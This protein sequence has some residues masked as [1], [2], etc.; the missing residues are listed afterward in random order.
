VSTRILES[1][2]IVLRNLR[3]GDTSR[4]ATLFTRS[5]G[6]IGGI[7]KGARDPKSPFG[8]SLELLSH[9]SFILYYRPGRDLQFLKT[10]E[11]LREYRGILREPRR[12]RYGAAWAEFLDRVVLEEEPA[13][14]LFLLA[15]RGLSVIESSP[16]AA[17]PEFFRGLQLRAASLMGYAPQLAACGRCGRTPPGKGREQPGGP[18]TH[19]LETA[20]PAEPGPGREAWLFSLSQGSILCPD[21]A[22]TPEP[23]G[24]AFFLSPRG[25]QRLRTMAL[26]SA[27]SGEAP[28]VRDVP[29][30]KAQASWVRL[31]DR[32]VE[33]FLRYHLASYR[34]LRSLDSEPDPPARF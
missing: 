33:G 28:Q 18:E 34:G 20:G 4:V 31:L 17:L 8:S 6:K 2:A 1:E 13:E 12:F 16:L 22:G 10:G 27:R 23:E 15:L 14:D 25:L 32:L 29:G 5:L 7:G 21:C 19:T 11:V 3:Y 9:S 24:E 30:G 26:G